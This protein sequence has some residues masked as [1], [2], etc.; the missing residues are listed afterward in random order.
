MKILILNPNQIKRRN[1]GHQLFRNEIGRQHEAVFYGPGFKGY[2][3]KLLDVRDI[4]KKKCPWKPDATLTYGWRYSKDFTG[5]GQITDIVKLHITVD[6]VRP[7]GVIRQNKWFKQNGYDM[8]FAITQHAYRAKVENKVADHIAIL[9]FSADTKIY[10]PMPNIKKE[11]RVLA[12]YTTR[13]DVYPNRLLARGALKKAGI[14]LLNKGVI[15]QALVQAI[16]RCKI[17]LTSN[18]IH[19]SFSMR[20]TETL[21]CG[22]FLLADEPE[23][24]TFLGY[25]DGEHLVIYKDLDDLV[26]KAKYYLDPKN[27]KERAKIAKQGMDFVRK[28]HS[29]KVRAQQFTELVRKELG[30]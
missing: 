14:K 28:N 29:C 30:I 12:A 15:H 1:W 16:N 5:L 17:T 11:D 24:L 8:I 18:N 27:E 19:R 4:I 21:S 26:D 7:A 6:Y 3:P 13:S 2:N 23:D 9:P 10:K 22:G 25:K 20:Y